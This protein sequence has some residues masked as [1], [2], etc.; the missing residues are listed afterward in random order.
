MISLVTRSKE[1]ANDFY[2]EFVAQVAGQATP[3]AKSTQS[4]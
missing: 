2:F 1:D 4:T 3:Q